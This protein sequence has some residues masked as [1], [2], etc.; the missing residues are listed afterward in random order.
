MMR[1]HIKDI[2]ILR[3]G[4]KILI[5]QIRQKKLEETKVQLL[6]SKDS[7]FHS[8]YKDYLT[9]MDTIKEL[10][11]KLKRVPFCGDTIEIKMDK[12]ADIGRYMTAIENRYGDEI[13]YDRIGF[14]R[15]ATDTDEQALQ[16]LFEKMIHSGREESDRYGNYK[17]YIK[18][19]VY[20][21]RVVEKELDRSG[22]LRK[23]I[24]QIPEAKSRCHITS[25]LRFHY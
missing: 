22:C 19:E 4:K 5:L 14:P 11:M 2:R 3:P 10:N 21:R 1:Q 8:L 18:T 17:N 9:A 20:L 24:N 15:E 6:H 13:D 12:N 23:I 7:F 25:F 16:A